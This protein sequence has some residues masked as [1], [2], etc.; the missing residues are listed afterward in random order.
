[1][2]RT[3]RKSDKDIAKKTGD[4]I[5]FSGTTYPG[6]PEITWKDHSDKKKWYK[7]GKKAKTYLHKG[8]K[9]KL[10]NQLARCYDFDD[11]PTVKEFHTDLWNYT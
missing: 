5:F 2:S 10:K 1:M 8:R 7:P 4:F 9:A 6:K 3:R 11:L